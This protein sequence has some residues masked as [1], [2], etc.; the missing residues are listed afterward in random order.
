MPQDNKAITS[1]PPCDDESIIDAD[2]G[3]AVNHSINELTTN[4]LSSITTH[5]DMN[6]PVD[7]HTAPE[8]NTPD[9]PSPVLGAPAA[10][11]PSIPTN[12]VTTVPTLHSTYDYTRGSSIASLRPFQIFAVYVMVFL[13][14]Q[15]WF[16][17][18]GRGNL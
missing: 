14:A 18:P 8:L 15:T 2:D 4:D 6:T 1:F 11:A 5:T 10:D 7:A 9:D 12:A 17:K 3:L 13:T 16:A